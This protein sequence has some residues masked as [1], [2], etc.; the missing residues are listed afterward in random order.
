MI[1]ESST[2]PS[3]V[4]A[5]LASIKERMLVTSLAPFRHSDLQAIASLR[6]IPVLVTD[7][8]PVKATTINPELDA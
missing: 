3:A 2:D 8:K 4:V 6:G 1:R 5:M 7:S